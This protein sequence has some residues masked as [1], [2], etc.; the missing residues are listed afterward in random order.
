[1]FC[2]SAAL[3]LDWRL[4]S[5]PVHARATY[6]PPFCLFTVYR[7]R[8]HLL[9]LLLLYYSLSSCLFVLRLLLLIYQLHT[10]HVSLLL[11]L[12]LLFNKLLASCLSPVL[13]L[14]LLLLYL[15]P[16]A[17]SSFLRFLLCN[18]KVYEA[19]PAQLCTWISIL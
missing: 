15:S 19:E 6:L 2:L 1:M 16:S 9:L 10:S 13:R 5:R 7:W 8:W 12:L 4:P 17:V 14:P 3:K 11:C 18:P